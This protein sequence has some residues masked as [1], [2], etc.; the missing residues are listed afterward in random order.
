MDQGNELYQNVILVM[1]DGRK[2]EF[3]GKV[4][5]DTEK[6]EDRKVV[7]ILITKPAPLPNGAKWGTVHSTTEENKDV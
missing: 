3:T 6:E 1:A 2:L 5:L 7:D 4:Q